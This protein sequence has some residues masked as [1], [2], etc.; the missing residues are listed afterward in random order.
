MPQLLP[1]SKRVG[2]GSKVPEI[3]S[4]T[5]EN[6]VES[7]PRKSFMFMTRSV[8]AHSFGKISAALRK[9]ASLY[10]KSKLL[11]QWASGFR[12]FFRVC[13]VERS[14]AYNPG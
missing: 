2:R 10:G 13:P 8:V 1:I 11:R 5:A 3:V 6:S 14:N 12:L 9:S 4:G 7:V